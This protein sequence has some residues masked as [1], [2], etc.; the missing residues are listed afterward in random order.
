MKQRSFFSSGLGLAFLAGIGLMVA[1][2]SPAIV[3]AYVQNPIFSARDAGNII[4]INM[5]GNALGALIT[6]FYLER[7]NWFRATIFCLLNLIF[8]D[9]ISI[10]INQPFPLFL[11][12]FIYGMTAGALMGIV[13]AAIAQTSGPERLQALSYTMQLL[14]GGILIQLITPQIE[15]AG[16]II[17]WLPLVFFSV[18]GLLLSPLLKKGTLNKDSVV[19]AK[20]QSRA[21]NLIIGLALASLFAFQMGQFAAFAYVIELGTNH[22]FS[23]GFT[24]ISV[25]MGLWIGGPAALFVTWWSLRSGR[26][27]PILLASS[28]QII[29]IGLLLVPHSSYFLIGNIAWGIAF[30][31][32]IS[33]ILGL[34][35]ELDNEGRTATLAAFASTLGLFAGPGLAAFLVGE[36]SYDRVILA[37]LATL[38]ASV[39]LIIIPAMKLDS[40]NKTRRI[41]WS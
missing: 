17:V 10:S 23:I 20:N 35:S 33:Y 18:I 38:F 5:L 28:I 16:T 25:A 36:N 7:F 14:S 27:L 4:S 12:R 9:L 8:L 26:T 40:L 13:Y 24:G 29:S 31:I 39:V 3:T 21:S 15:S 37:S 41:I 19:E 1:N 34:I 11:V 30:N 2:I 6:S 32:G 22:N